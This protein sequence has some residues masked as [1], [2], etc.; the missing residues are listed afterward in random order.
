MRKASIDTS[1]LK[2][3]EL[4]PLLVDAAVD[5]VS[6]RGVQEQVNGELGTHL[7]ANFGDITIMYRTP[8]AMIFTAPSS[9]GVDIWHGRKC[10]SVIWDSNQLK[11]F[12]IISFK[13]GP[14]IPLVISFAEQ[15]N[16]DEK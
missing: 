16:G 13:R 7:T 8:K 11:D 9:F 6:R 4:V 15:L 10:F 5:I 1:R 2:R 12:E 3:S 14:W